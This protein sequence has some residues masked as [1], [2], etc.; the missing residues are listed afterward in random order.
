[1]APRIAALAFIV[2]IA[3][4][5]WLD[6][7]KD[8]KASKALWIPFMWF[9]IACSRALSEWIYL[10]PP[11]A[12]TNVYMEGSPLDRNFYLVLL[13]LGLLILLSRANKVAKILS[14]NAPIL[15]YILYGAVSVLWSDYPEIGIKRWI[16]A[17]GDLVMIL[18]VLTDAEPVVALKRLFAR[19]GFLLLPLSVLFIRYYPDLGRSYNRWT[20]EPSFTGVSTNKNMLGLI[21]L[22]CGLAAVWRL[23]ALRRDKTAPDRGRHLLAQGFLVLNAMYILLIAHSATSM[24]CF[25]M[26][27]VL[28]LAAG[29][30][31]FLRRPGRLHLLTAGEVCLAAFPLFLGASRLLEFLGRDP[32]LTG[33][34]EIWREIL[35]VAP[36]PMLGTG[37]GTFWLGNRLAALRQTFEGNPLMES[38]NG[39]I[40]VYVN[41]GMIG[42]ILLSI[43][44]LVGYSR[45]F[46]ALRQKAEDANLRLAFMVIVVIYNFTEAAFKE[47]NPVW[48]FFLYAAITPPKDP[49]PEPPI[50]VFSQPAKMKF[51]E[52]NALATR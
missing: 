4:L 12:Q 25:Y 41:L 20:W 30:P 52:T 45:I 1:M 36:S 44:I 24:S 14:S 17:V 27:A 11:P 39:Y 48:I 21:A 33:R 43:I 35:K 7:D 32:T 18:I 38:H 2:G 42:V 51:R 46:V 37:Y 6:R 22:I 19:L 49:A 3:G 10:G 31:A 28:I 8:H 47:L 29:R 16:K 40:E 23:A 26:G 34:I 5:F 13:I 15:L 50:P 9:F